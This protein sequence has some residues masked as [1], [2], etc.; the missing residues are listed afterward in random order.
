VHERADIAPRQTADVFA[1]AGTPAPLP[2]PHPN[3]DAATS[4]HAALRARLRVVP[5]IERIACVAHQLVC[6]PRGDREHR[7]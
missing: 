6:V 2:S 1:I 3:K 4:G 7:V 5:Q